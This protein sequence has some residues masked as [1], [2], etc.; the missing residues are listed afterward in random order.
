MAGK[1][2]ERC[3]GSPP[4]PSALCSCLSET[5]S[6]SKTG[7]AKGNRRSDLHLRAA[8][9]P[10]WSQ[11][12]PLQSRRH[13][14][15][16]GYLGTTSENV[17]FLT[18]NRD[19]H[20]AGSSMCLIPHTCLLLDLPHVFEIKYNRHKT[21]NATKKV[22][23]LGKVVLDITKLLYFKNQALGQALFS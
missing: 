7:R 6:A 15:R 17:S 22:K 8:S 2:K 23:L 11:P 9:E 13:K 20:V 5:S 14:G 21:R 12:R 19:C 4:P 16:C 10:A 1:E 3:L 18:S